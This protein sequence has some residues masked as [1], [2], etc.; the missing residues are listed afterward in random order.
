MPPA[1]QRHSAKLYHAWHDKPV[2]FAL[3][4][5]AIYL[6]LLM[7]TLIRHDFNFSVFIVAGDQFVNLSQT[8]LPILVRPHSAGYDG[9]FYYALAV[10]PFHAGAAA[11]GIVI[12]HPSWRAQRIIYPLVA[13][14]VALG[15]ASFVP[16]AM[17][18]V[19]IASLFALACLVW[20]RLPHLPA[21]AI[22]LWPG[23]L[24]ALTHDTTE[25]LTCAMLFA[26]LV[27]YIDGRFAL[28]GILAAVAALTRETS[29]LLLGG[30]ALAGAAGYWRDRRSLLDW[31]AARPLLAAGAAL[32]PFLLWH[33]YLAWAWG[34]TKEQFP[35]QANVGWPLAGF[36]TRFYLTL[37]KLFAVHGTSVRL[38][39]MDVYF[40]AVMFLIAAFTILMANS[41]FRVWRCGG[42]PAAI[43]LGWGCMLVLMSL[44][45]ASRPWAEPTAAFRVFSETWLVGWL[46]IS[47]DQS[48]RLSWTIP[49][50]LPIT[51]INYLVCIIQ[52]RGGIVSH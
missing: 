15:R 40:L 30:I 11:H 14:A 51:A 26:A 37:G 32:V 1:F 7:P 20:R 43:A 9:Q 38:R 47:R 46:L 29:S 48:R 12:D 8:N 44:L 50:L 21:L 42:R 4:A 18:A 25:I 36:A 33:A 13:S 6:L 49:A 23:L 19:N 3:L 41:A 27:A 22:M 16:A 17:V 31:Q 10:D 34:G 2:A 5:T 24:T 35:L 28:F 45:S 39:L 52:L